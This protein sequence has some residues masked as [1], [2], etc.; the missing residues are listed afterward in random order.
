MMIICTNTALLWMNPVLQSHSSWP[1]SQCPVISIRRDILSIWNIVWC[2]SDS[3]H[4][5]D[6]PYC[7]LF[8]LVDLYH[9]LPLAHSLGEL[10]ICAALGRILSIAEMNWQCDL[11][12]L[13][14]SS[15]FKISMI[16]KVKEVKWNY[17]HPSL[18]AQS[19]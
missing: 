16:T 1:L 2:R 17:P 3:S 14:S 15:L 13:I 8:W 9:S 7:V 12:Y 4:W 11:V 18:P 10:L 5:S 6:L 19:K